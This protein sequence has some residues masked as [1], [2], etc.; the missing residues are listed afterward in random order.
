MARALAC[1]WGE[2]VLVSDGG[3]GRANALAAELGGEALER[4]GVRP[5]FQAAFGAVVEWGR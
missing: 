1:G 5:A 3:S 4:G 2:P